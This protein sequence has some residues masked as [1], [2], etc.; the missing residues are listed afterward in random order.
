MKDFRYYSDCFSSLHTAKKLGKPAPHKALLL[1][2]IIDLVE[3]SVIC[4]NHIELSDTLVRTFNINAK[5]FY[6]NSPIFKP[7]ITKPFVHM[8]YE[9]F[10]RLV[11]TSECAESAMAA[12]SMPNYGKRK[13]SYS[14]KGLREQ[15]R[16]A[17]IDEELYE[18]LKDEDVRARL[19]VMLISTYLNNRIDLYI[20]ITALPLYLSILST[21][22]C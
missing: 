12:E 13:T 10:W 14:L 6:A 9:P 3:R 5:K 18:L 15:Y 11:A 19:R 16:Y 20:P 2:S 22:A 1:L 8:Q 7:E 21:L 17:E 4:G